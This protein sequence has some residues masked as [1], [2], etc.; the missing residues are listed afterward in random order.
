ME[1]HLLIQKYN[2]PAPR[3]TSYPTIPFWDKDAPSADKWFD[4][5]K[6]TFV[7]SNQQKGI[8]LYIHL[9]YCESLCT[10][11]GCNTRITKNHS[12]EKSYIKTLLKEWQLYLEQFPEKP[13]IRELHLGGGTPTFFSP[14]NLRMLLDGIF[15]EAI[16]HPEWEFSFEGHP[17]NTT[18]EH[19]QTL[20][21][22]GFR[23]VSFGIQDCDPL[24]QLTINRVQPFENVKFVTEEARRIGYESVNFDLIY[25]LPYQTINSVNETINQ[26]STL[27]PDRI[28]FYS[29][30]HVPWVKPGQRSYTDK[31]LPD[32]LL[33]RALYELA[34]EKFKTLGYMD[35]G[36]D[37]FA[38]P[39]DPLFNAMETKKLHRNFMGYTTCHTDLLIGLGASSI[40]D[41]KYAYL[42]NEKKVELYTL[43][44]EENKLPVFKGHLLT[45]KDLKIKEVILAI[46]C[47][48][49]IKWDCK[50]INLLDN[51]AHFELGK[52]QNDGLVHLSSDYLKVT[53][54]GKAFI[55]NICMVF[56]S[57][58]KKQLAKEEVFS[59]A[60]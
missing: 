22:M 59:K 1:K 21:D 10:Y 56:D 52:M 17:N 35:I 39:R 16:I 32:S 4:V 29:Y 13:I 54:I 27:M 31:D 34:L 15:Q 45:E 30:A 38:L 48:G 12:V 9:P 60:I 42:Q 7:E 47:R 26:V 14:G 24:V 36:M 40:S 23:R 33:K 11:C 46:A 58:L 18:S 55:R 8:S 20:F 2:V 50:L 6:R 37:H 49:E 43:S 5:V 28:A 41:A 25:G 53:A 57:K 19:L 3:Y 44:L 51:E